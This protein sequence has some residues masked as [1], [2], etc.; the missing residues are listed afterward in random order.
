MTSITDDV[1]TTCVLPRDAH[2]AVPLT[3]VVRELAVALDMSRYR[4]VS[5][6]TVIGRFFADYAIQLPTDRTVESVADEIML[7]I[8]ADEVYDS[9]Q[10]QAERAAA[11]VLYALFGTSTI[12]VAGWMR[13]QRVTHDYETF[14]LTGSTCEKCETNP[15]CYGTTGSGVRCLDVSGCGWTFCF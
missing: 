14:A 3:T 5:P 10:A 15:E 2:R 9:E 11:A 13:G 4:D 7:H 1:T 12:E 6:T 8:F